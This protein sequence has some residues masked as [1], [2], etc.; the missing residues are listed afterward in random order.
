[1]CHKLESNLQEYQN[2]QELA[3]KLP[4]K[5]INVLVMVYFQIPPDP[6]AFEKPRRAC[7]PQSNSRPLPAPPPERQPLDR[8]PSDPKPEKSE[9]RP[10]RPETRLERDRLT[11]TRH[12]NERPDKERH[13]RPEWLESRTDRSNSENRILDRHSD[14]Y[15]QE[16]HIDFRNPPERPDKPD[17]QNDR[18]SFD[19]DTRQENRAPPRQRSLPST[20]SGGCDSQP[21]KSTTMPKFPSED[22]KDPPYEN[23]AVEKNELAVARMYLFYSIKFKKKPLL[24][25]YYVKIILIF[26]VIN[27]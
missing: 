18:S 5:N 6:R 15:V 14:R 11:D 4:L 23:V 7:T 17:R 20:T 21:T 12:P 13:D 2:N 26:N 27:I 16:R 9:P 19:R 10:D 3:L 22:I 25:H 8:T 24:R 1:M